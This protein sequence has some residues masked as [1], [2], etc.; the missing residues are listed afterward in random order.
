M[1][2]PNLEPMFVHNQYYESSGNKLVGCMCEVWVGE[3]G[4]ISNAD[5]L[6]G[7]CMLISPTVW[8]GPMRISQKSSEYYRKE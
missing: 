6:V 1:T 8:H 7:C 3:L 2:D 5:R 4:G